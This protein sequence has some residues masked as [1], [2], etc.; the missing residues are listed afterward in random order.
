MRVAQ[1]RIPAIKTRANDMRKQAANLTRLTQFTRWLVLRLWIW[2]AILTG[3]AEVTAQLERAD[4]MKE[5]ERQMRA[6]AAKDPHRPLYHAAPPAFTMGDPN[7][8][9]QYKGIYH[10]FYQHV[11]T[12]GPGAGVEW[13]HLTSTD[14]F[15]WKEQP[16]AI[17][18]G[19]EWKHCF[20]GSTV[21]HN[22]TPTAFFTG[23]NATYPEVPC[24]AIAQDDDLNVWH[25]V[26]G[27]PVIK[28]RP[29]GLPGGGF[30]DPY[31]WREGDRFFMGLA[32]SLPGGGAILLYR[33]PDLKN[34]NYVG[35]LYQGKQDPGAQG[36]LFECPSFFALGDK[37]FLSFNKLFSVG[38]PPK[39]ANARRPVYM[40][41]NYTNHQ[42]TPEYQ[43]DLDLFNESWAPQAF[44]D[45][46][47]RWLVF[48][49][50][51][52]ARTDQAGWVG[53]QTMP[54]RVTLGPDQRPRFRPV[55]EVIQ[56]RRAH[57][58]YGKMKIDFTSKDV[59]KA[60]LQGD[61][62]QVRVV[63][64]PGWDAKRFGA[65]VRKS[66]DEKEF[67]RIL[68]DAEQGRMIAD[69]KYSSP[70][71]SVHENL[72]DERGAVNLP[73]SRP[74]VFD[75][76]LDK[77]VIEVFVDDGVAAGITRVYPSL[78]SLGIDLFAEGGTVTVRSVDAWDM[79]P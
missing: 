66:Q 48:M 51:W 2:L 32:T 54:R 16:G 45:E 21:V 18:P 67:T 1:E 46:H 79:V 74:V 64:E 33:S 41:G 10:L 78:K 72:R 9:I 26:E 7:G 6:L 8:L 24:I 34:W 28:E 11:P 73:S 53:T 39:I 63:F 44:K 56:L 70:V 61:C 27:N 36:E 43:A 23:L 62:M 29:T 35:K 19:K 58:H 52:C 22:G 71:G 31:V 42:F 38:D 59:F 55:D 49:L 68:Y 47:D 50:T 20:S 15:H 69:R 13:A 12:F 3:G 77:S 57:R 37:F 75:I 30:R 4:S 14:L 65:V 25:H 60:G 17:F 40:I 5:E 76:F